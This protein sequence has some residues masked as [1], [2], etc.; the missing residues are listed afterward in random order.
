MTSGSH[1]KSSI[2]SPSH[3]PLC[4]HVCRVLF[5]MWGKVQDPELAAQTS[6][7]AIILSTTGTT[8]M[9]RERT[10]RMLCQSFFSS[11]INWIKIIVGDSSKYFLFL[12]L[13]QNS[14]LLLNLCH[15]AI[16]LTSMD[17]SLSKLWELVMD[18]E[19]WHA[20]VHGVAKSWTRLSD[21]TDWLTDPLHL[22]VDVICPH[23][24]HHHTSPIKT[25]VPVFL[26]IPVI[27]AGMTCPI[28]WPSSWVTLLPLI[29]SLKPKLATKFLS[30]I[31]KF[32]FQVYH[33]LIISSYSSGLLTAILWLIRL[34]LPFLFICLP[35]PDLK[36]LFTHY[37]LWAIFIHIHLLK[38]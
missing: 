5:A 24:D 35:H 8:V 6:V 30:T 13:L 36:Y 25:L 10:R 12:F 4:N 3:G 38:Y 34:N 9:R 28:L 11:S 27:F 22:L 17:M 14:L 16:L 31:L 26:F 33:S 15:K 32:Q 29:I 21:W 23:P 20:A 1:R 7:G 18:R 2:S 19:A 37:I